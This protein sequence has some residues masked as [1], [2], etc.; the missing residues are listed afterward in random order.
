MHT[1]FGSETQ[2][3][4]GL[5]KSTRLKNACCSFIGLELSSLHLHQVAHKQIAITPA[6][7]V[8]PLLVSIGTAYMSS[9]T[10]THNEIN[11]IP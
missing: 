9:Y 3:T 4:K 1:Y 8:C 2:H 6:L 10:H 7:G 5:G 11:S